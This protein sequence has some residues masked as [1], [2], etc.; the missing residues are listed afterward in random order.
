MADPVPKDTLALLKTADAG[1]GK[2][3]ANA[4]PVA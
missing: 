3:S 2:S 4:S 1:I